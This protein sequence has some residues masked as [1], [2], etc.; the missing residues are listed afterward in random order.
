MSLSLCLSVLNMNQNVK[1][2]VEFMANS[3]FILYYIN[4]LALDKV[5]LQIILVAD[6][7]MLEL[8]GSQV[9]N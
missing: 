3:Q 9:T 5:G 4:T 2:A 8:K 1:V 6:L 7:R